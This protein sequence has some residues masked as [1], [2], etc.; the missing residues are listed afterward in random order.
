MSDLRWVVVAAE[1]LAL[2]VLWLKAPAA[3][4]PLAFLP[5][6]IDPDQFVHFTA[7][8][9]T[10]YLWV[11]PLMGTAFLLRDRRYL[12]A[13]LLF[14]T[15]A[16]V[17]QQ[18]WLLAPFLCIWVWY[19]H[20]DDPLLQR[21]RPVAVFVAGS[22]AAFLAFNLPF[23][24]W[25][26]EGWLASVF[27]PFHEDLIPFGSG[28]SMLTQVGAAQ[29]PKSFYTLATFGVWAILLIAYATHFR[30]LKYAVWL[31]PGLV[32]WFSYRSL[33][34]YFIYWTPLLIIAL[35]FWWEDSQAGE[36]SHA[37]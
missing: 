15:A 32:L 19:D 34:S 30:A 16:A 37:A 7:G 10:D 20:E 33:Q 1:I 4:R 26:F 3:I 24:L 14:G 36:E 11:L 8:G 2:A 31:L 25:D 9:V 29:L 5:I 28:L 17:K 12:A 35:F 22:L 27:L 21:L 18:P 13:A 23:A 6:A